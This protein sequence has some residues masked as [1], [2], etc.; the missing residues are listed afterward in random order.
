MS[1]GKGESGTNNLLVRATNTSKFATIEWL[2][3]EGRE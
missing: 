2:V 1:E 3:Q